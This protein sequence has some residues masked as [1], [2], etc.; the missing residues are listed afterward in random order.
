MKMKGIPVWEQYLEFIVLGIAVLVFGGLVAMQFIGN[1]NAVEDPRRGVLGPG[2][3]DEV[4]ESEANRLRPH[5]ETNAQPAIEIPSPDPVAPE[6]EQRLASAV[7]PSDTLALPQLALAPT[8]TGTVIVTDVAFVEPQL[9]APYDVIAQQ[10]F[11]AL[12]A[13]VVAQREPLQQRFPDEP[14][15]ITWITAAANFDIAAALDEFRRT[16]PD[17]RPAPVPPSWYD[18]RI[19]IVDVVIEREQQI[20]GGWTNHSV[21]EPI[22]GQYTVRPWLDDPE[23]TP[24]NRDELQ[25]QLIVSRLMVDL[26]QPEFYATRNA[27]W[28]PPTEQQI[29]DESLTPDLTDEQRQIMR[30]QRDLARYRNE[31]NRVAQLLQEA[32]GELYSDD[33]GGAGGGAGGAAGGGGGSGRRPPGGGMAG[34]ASGTGRRPFDDQVRKKRIALT[35]QRDNLSEEITR[36]EEQLTRLGALV[37]DDDQQADVDPMEAVTVRI[38]GHDLDITPGATYRYRFTVRVLNPYFRREV[39]L[40]EDQKHLADPFYIETSPSEWSSPI[41]AKPPV[42]TFVVSATPATGDNTPGRLGLG[43]TSVEVFRFYDGRWWK[44]R[45]AVEPG[46][47][48]GQVASIRQPE[49]VMPIVIDFGTDWFVLDI[50]SDL[51]ADQSTDR[52][53]AASVLLQSM[54]YPD[55]LVWRHPKNDA[56]SLRR[57]ELDERVRL[58][59]LGEGAQASAQ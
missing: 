22:P 40:L 51:T 34:G 26:M 49:Q 47:R 52:G 42:E 56:D 6:Y 18:G 20:N 8:T 9:P 16:G 5:F 17:G 29:T 25:Q 23:L 50:V 3:I 11:D 39:H 35:T 38:W 27:S 41:L 30:L 55:Q 7:A 19:T 43:Q 45:F 44:E 28:Y 48:I 2:E 59:E 31:Y 37:E 14:Y 24:G 33:D 53:R 15:D 36:I 13:E 32:G 21:V 4:L 12:P 57:L 54:K 46:E 1:P 10:Y 58:A